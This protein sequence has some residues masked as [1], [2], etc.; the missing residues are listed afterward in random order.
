VLHGWLELLWEPADGLV[1]AGFN[2]EHVPGAVAPDF[3]ASGAYPPWR[4]IAAKK[5]A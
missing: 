5:I 2:D 4:S 1:I 3:S